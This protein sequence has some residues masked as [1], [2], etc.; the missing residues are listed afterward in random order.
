MPDDHVDARTCPW[1]AAPAPETAT[2]CPACGAAL[3]QRESIGGLVIPGVTTVDPALAAIDGRP[4]RLPGNSPTQGM[5]GGVARAAAVGGPVALAAIGGLA[6]VAAAEYLGAGRGGSG[7]PTHLADVGRPSEVALRALENL[8]SQELGASP[9]EPP[10]DPD[11]SSDPWRDL[12][13]EPS[14]E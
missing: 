8:D 1:C 7:G 5:A 11:G 6:A 2:Q 9:S 12:P 14:T 4:M 13:S 3:A 10:S